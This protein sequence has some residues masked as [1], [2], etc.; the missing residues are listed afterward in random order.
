MQIIFMHVRNNLFAAAVSAITA[1]QQP[2]KRD[3][4]VSGLVAPDKIAEVGKAAANVATLQMIDSV[5]VYVLRMR[6]LLS[7]THVWAG[8]W[9]PLTTQSSSSRR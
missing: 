8:R 5:I 7:W 1:Y 2:P 9:V 6:F 4:V 3:R